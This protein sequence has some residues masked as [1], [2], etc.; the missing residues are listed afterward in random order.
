MF[1]QNHLLSDRADD[2]FDIVWGCSWRRMYRM[3][4]GFLVVGAR[5]YNGGGF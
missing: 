1:A 4:V 3:W 2:M 5:G